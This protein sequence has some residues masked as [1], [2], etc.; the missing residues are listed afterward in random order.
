M[1]LVPWL[2]TEVLLIGLTPSGHAFELELAVDHN[3][4][5]CSSD[6]AHHVVGS[7]LPI[8]LKLPVGTSSRT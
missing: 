4:V 1:F 3:E 7:F 8:I 5:F 6:V 2:A